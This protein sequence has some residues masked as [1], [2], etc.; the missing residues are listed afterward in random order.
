MGAQCGGHNVHGASERLVGPGGPAAAEIDDSELCRREPYARG[1][2]SITVLGASGDLAKKETYPALL[3]LFLHAL[4]PQHVCIVG[5]AR[6][7][8]TTAEFH[9]HLRPW[10]LRAQAEPATVERFLS[11]CSYFRGDYQSEEDFGRLHAK[12]RGLEEATR[13][14]EP[15]ATNRLF[16]F[17]IPPEMFLAS[18]RSIKEAA[19]CCGFTRLI[20]E[21]PFGHDLA[22][23]RRLASELEAVFS[24]DHI[25]RIDH[26]LGK[27][28]VQN[29]MMF[30][31]GNRF[32]EP[33]LN[34]NHVASV[35]ITLK[36]DFGTMG[37]G[38]YF[39][40][41]G[42]IRDVIQNHLMQVLSLLAMEPPKTLA[43]PKAASQVRGAKVAVLRAVRAISPSE[44]VLGQ[45]VGN[46]S[47][48]GYLE[49]ESIRD[50]ESAAFVPTF[51]AMVLRLGSARWRGVPFH[52]KAGKAL[53][54]S[55]VEIRIQFKDAPRSAELFGGQQCARNELVMRLEPRE[56]IYMKASVK[57]PGLQS[58]PLQSELDLT[59]GQRFGDTYRPDAYARLLLEA[60]QG[61]QE[62]FVCSGELEASWKLFD[63][64]LRELEVGRRRAL[65]LRY[66]FGS[67]G[68][69]EADELFARNGFEHVEG[70]YEWHE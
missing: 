29:L 64:L 68:P 53:D 19:M 1:Q 25:Y 57:A 69:P 47:Q 13:P 36:E 23:A 38:G 65:P 4:L 43:G 24:D 17:A 20:V 40:H 12:L 61:R 58:A 56:A 21:K 60:L 35:R 9:D 27:E 48:P 46:G 30:R 14:L 32:L 52:V 2:L 62:N 39:T 45:Y 37:R 22:S 16:Y 33:L 26:Y 8:Q 51:A 6:T 10:L 42:I 11:R 50:K 28:I 3:D 34:R 15:S 55:K 44:V 66:A 54:E 31:F 7:E 67:R 41:Y 63:P 18:A 70:A 49:D 59:Y 5:F